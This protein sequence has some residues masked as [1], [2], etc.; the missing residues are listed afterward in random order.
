MVQDGYRKH[1]LTPVTMDQMAQVFVRSLLENIQPDNISYCMAGDTHLFSIYALSRYAMIEA[2]AQS[3]F[4]S[5]LHEIDPEF[6]SH[7]L[8]FNDYAWQVVMRYP[9]FFGRLPVSKPR[10]KMMAIMKQFVGRPVSSNTQ[11]NAFVR[12]VLAGMEITALDMHSRAAMML[13][14]F[15]AAVSNE[16]NGTFWL[17]A[18]LL[19]DEALLKQVEQETEAAW[20]SGKLNIKHLTENCP[21]LDATFNEVLRHKNAAGAMRRVAEKTRIGNKEL[22]PGSIAYIPFHQ[23]H[24]NEGVWGDNSLVFDHTRFLKRKSLARNASFRPFGGGATYCPGRTLAKQ[25]VFSAI[26]IILHRFDVRLAEVGHGKQQFPILNV[27]TPS[28][29]LNG[30]IKGMDVIA[31]MVPKQEK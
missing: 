10:K 16:Y 3:M 25:E 27:K 14:I 29:G 28:L 13:M 23:I 12:N 8:A 4:G 26:A 7:M 15:W 31:E 20:Q 19:H 9:D 11:A 6:A 22:Q 1:L 18:H 24:T 2:S 17:M 30:P 5:H 21:I